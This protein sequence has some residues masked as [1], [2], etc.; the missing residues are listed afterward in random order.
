[1]S[2]ADNGRGIPEADRDAVFDLFVR[3]PGGRDVAGSGIGLA[4]CARIAEALGGQITISDSDGGGV[5]FTLAVP[6]KG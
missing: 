1:M 3:L 4:T 2:V 5:T 6:T